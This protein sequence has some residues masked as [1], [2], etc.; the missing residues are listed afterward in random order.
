MTTLSPHV[1]VAISATP[2]HQFAAHINA[3]GREDKPGGYEE[4]PSRD[5]AYRL[6]DKIAA[7]MERT[8]ADLLLLELSPRKKDKA[9]RWADMTFGLDPKWV[10]D[11]I[12]A[13][14]PVC[15]RWDTVLYT[16]LSTPGKL[17]LFTQQALAM[18]AKWHGSDTSGTTSKTTLRMDLIDMSADLGLPMLI[19]GPADKKNPG[20][21]KYGCVATS[22]CLRVERAGGYANSFLSTDHNPRQPRIGVYAGGKQNAVDPSWSGDWR[23]DTAKFMH[24]CRSRG[25]IPAA[26][27]WEQG[28]FADLLATVAGERV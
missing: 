25:I 23:T 19:E 26:A 21:L 9:G 27:P 4:P 1:A 14:Q 22:V 8:G 3:C 17:G 28:K 2:T 10:D 16:G 20:L 24:H 6:A 12:P 5:A 15:R 11:L 13:M 18:G 7:A